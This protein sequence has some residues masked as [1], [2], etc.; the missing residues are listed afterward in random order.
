MSSNVPERPKIL[1]PSSLGRNKS[2]LKRNLSRKND[3]FG[4]LG[5]ATITRNAKLFEKPKEKP[6][7]WVRMSKTVTCCCPSSVLATFGIPGRSHQAWREKITLFFISLLMMIATIY[8]LLFFSNT[9]CPQSVIENTVPVKIFGGVVIFGTM[10]KAETMQAPFNTLFEQ[11]EASFGGIDVSDVFQREKIPACLKPEVSQYRFAQLTSPCEPNDC[12]TLNSLI[13]E[14]GLQKFTEI[15]GKNNEI[16][17]LEP[18]P[19]YDWFDVKERKLVVYRQQVLNFSSY[20]AEYPAAIPGDPV[21]EF[22]RLAQSLN[23][24]TKLMEQSKTI[25]GDIKECLLQKYQ[26][27]ILDV[28]PMSCILTRL[29]TW[30]I[31]GT[32]LVILFSKFLMALFFSWFVSAK[33]AKTP[34]AE[35]ISDYYSKTPAPKPLLYDDSKAGFM[36]NVTDG[37]QRGVS[38]LMTKP[39]VKTPKPHP[40]DL[41]VALLVTCYSE[42]VESI[43][44]TLNS[45][46]A[47]IYDDSKKLLF[48]VSDGLVKGFENELSTPEILIKL[49]Q[50][51]PRFTNLLEPQPYVSI[52][53]GAKEHNMA[54]VFCG[55]YMYEGRAIPM[56]LVVKCG[57]KEEE[58]SPKPGILSFYNRKSREKGLSTD[59]DEFFF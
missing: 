54:Q 2:L 14:R 59:L 23:D 42:G 31:S 19:A 30:V 55:S 5:H 32:V 37:R 18:T 52:G 51:D 47:T 44:N 8:F 24:A 33:L 20:F 15:V 34:D 25:S 49:M 28:L 12:L 13:N 43:R 7:W 56:I 58:N 21:D 39:H 29:F 50:H 1:S 27:G 22:M 6:S 3:R 40:A 35:T 36:K 4:S 38:M 48:V 17:K 41:F 16:V 10:Y 9:V 11:S 26:V 45:L 57:T 53:T 46:A